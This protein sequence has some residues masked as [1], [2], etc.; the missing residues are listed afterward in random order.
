MMD[1]E[2]QDLDSSCSTFVSRSGNVNSG[3][4]GGVNNGMLDDDGTLHAFCF[5]D[6]DYDYDL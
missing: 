5:V 2:D 1:K 3:R 6:Y 4:R